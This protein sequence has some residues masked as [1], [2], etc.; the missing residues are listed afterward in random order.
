[1]TP[2]PSQAADRRDRALAGGEA[3]V[4]CR[5]LH[6]DGHAIWMETNVAVVPRPEG[7]ASPPMLISVSRN[8]EARKQLEL[9][10][11]EARR[12]AEAAAAAKSDFLANMTHELRTPLNAI[13]GFSGNSPGLAAPVSAEDARH[14]HLI[15]DASDTLLVLV[16]SVL[17][18]SR[19]EAG[20]VTLEAKAFDPA[21]RVRA[22]A[23][24]LAEQASAKGLELTGAWSRATSP[25][26][27]ATRLR[28][29]SKCC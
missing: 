22:T 16:N 25:P 11:V 15:S 26:W 14:A 8:I 17:D 5:M 28:A 6:K 20:A 27:S 19:L 12:S 7:G 1:M 21:A 13:I 9:E 23:T 2:S 4:Q 10:L 3:I 29:S 24:M 18:F